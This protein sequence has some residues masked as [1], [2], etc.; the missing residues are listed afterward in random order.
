M[1]FLLFVG[2]DHQLGD[3]EVMTLFPKAKNLDKGLY[4][5]SFDSKEV[6]VEAVSR[7]GSAIKLAGKI[8]EWKEDFSDIA[9][10]VSDAANFSVTKVPFNAEET[11]QLN[12]QTKQAIGK[13]ARFIL[14]KDEFGVSPLLLQRQKVSEVIIYEKFLYQTVWTHDV[15]HWIE[16]DR[17]LPFANAYKGLLPPKIARILINLSGIAPG[18][19]ICLLDPFCGS[20]RVLI[21][22][23]E[24]G[25]LVVG[26]D[27]SADQVRE[28]SKNLSTL[29]HP[30]DS[31]S[32]SV[33]DATQVLKLL[34]PKSVNLIV[35]EPFMG[36]PNPRQDRIADMVKGLRKLYLGALKSWLPILKEQGRV[37][38]I[39]PRFE[40]AKRTYITSSVV[41]DSHLFGYNVKTRNLMYSRPGAQ[42]LR[43]I[44]ILEKKL[45]N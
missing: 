18:T 25:Y 26:F 41:D 10:L 29:N 43:E 44:V 34:P 13:Q 30:S 27:I 39:F 21:E 19:D 9:S 20:G 7:M 42:L 17:L 2:A 1:E 23:V 24:L 33:G 37:V 12:Q 36:K 28:S 14:P 45:S 22:G 32:V 38:M 8:G 5:L 35:T 6:A 31:Y 4:S 3:Y 16:K 40:D 11:S 15:R